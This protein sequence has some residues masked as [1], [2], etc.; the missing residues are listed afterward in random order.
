MTLITVLQIENDA[1]NLAYKINQQLDDTDTLAE[2]LSELRAA[3]ST[4]SVD[5]N[6]VT[7]EVQ[8]G[9]WKV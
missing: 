8:D 4:Y 6:L 3:C 5:I 1:D 9:N 2:C 7:I